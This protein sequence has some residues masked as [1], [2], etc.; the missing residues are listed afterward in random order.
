MLREGLMLNWFRSRKY[1]SGTRWCLW[2]WTDDVESEQ[3]I[4]RLH[5]LKTPWGAVCVHWL[6]RPDPESALH[7]HPCSFLSLILRGG[8]AEARWK[9]GEWS[10]PQHRWFNFVRATPDDRHKITNVD[11]G[12]VTL[13]FMS[14]KTREWG[15]HV[16]TL[17][18]HRWLPWR[19][20]YAEKRA[21]LIR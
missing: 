1:R 16:P 9:R 4:T 15:Y 7:D 20:Y 17:V 12:T 21:G 11:P 2:R 6:H 19:E 5:L 8:Y 18:G 3:Y 14:G 10:F 13:C